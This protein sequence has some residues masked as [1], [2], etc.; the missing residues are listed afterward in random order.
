MLPS[1]L[2]ARAAGCIPGALTTGIETSWI[3]GGSGTKPSIS[4]V[5]SQMNDGHLSVKESLTLR[6]LLGALCVFMFTSF[7]LVTLFSW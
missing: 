4:D 3:G 2:Q 1:P 5:P 6:P 7:H